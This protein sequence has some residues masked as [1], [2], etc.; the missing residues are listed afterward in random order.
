MYVTSIAVSM[1]ASSIKWPFQ[2]TSLLTYMPRRIR[3]LVFTIWSAWAF[4]CVIHSHHPCIHGITLDRY[5]CAILCVVECDRWLDCLAQMTMAWLLCVE[6]VIQCRA[7]C[8][9]MSNAIDYCAWLICGLQIH[10]CVALASASRNA[11]I[12]KL[13]IGTGQS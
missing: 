9:Y 13:T 10:M 12:F 11:D 6:T 2:H 5:I 4:D 8:I 1:F 7:T 3:M